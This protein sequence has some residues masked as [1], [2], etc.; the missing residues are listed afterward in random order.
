M[1]I[2][3][4][5]S[6]IFLI[7]APAHAVDRSLQAFAAACMFAT[8]E[9]RTNKPYYPPGWDTAG[10]KREVRPQ[11]LDALRSVTRRGVITVVEGDRPTDPAALEGL[12]MLYGTEM[13]FTGDH[14][15]GM[16]YRVMGG[17]VL[18][19]GYSPRLARV[20]RGEMNPH[21]GYT[22]LV[23]ILGDK[24]FEYLYAS[25]MLPGSMGKTF[26]ARE[27]LMQPEFAAAAEK[28]HSIRDELRSL[29]PGESPAEWVAEHQKRLEDAINTFLDT[30]E[31]LF[32][33]GVFIKQRVEWQTGDAKKQLSSKKRRT[34]EWTREYLSDLLD[35]HAELGFHKENPASERMQN[36]IGEL[37]GRRGTKFVN[38]LLFSPQDLLVQEK[39][40]LRMSGKFMDEWRVT[41]IDGQ[42]LT[43]VP[44]YGWEYSPQ[45]AAE[46]SAFFKEFSSK[47]SHEFKY[48]SGGADVAFTTDGKPK[49][50]ELNTGAEAGGVMPEFDPVNSNLNL[51]ALLGKPTPLVQKLG[52]LFQA[53]VEEQAAFVRGAK[54]YFEGLGLKEEA[55][56]N[57]SADYVLVYFRDRYLQEWDKGKHTKKEA[58]SILSKL[59]K[60]DKGSTPSG[61]EIIASA[62]AYL[63]LT[64]E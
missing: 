40:P 22:H 27:M 41:F 7:S 32:P 57:D 33:D 54:A 62:E 28:L 19:P 24:W 16:P 56:L 30:G 44:R 60:I 61:K 31:K 26:R 38:S 14:P 23:P 3:L 8:F 47:A 2:A 36:K 18:H 37:E 1:R 35:I 4:T 59:K 51:S 43:V 15:L 10:I 58:R 12:Q 13:Y 52:G 21:L 46:V 34:E 50:I 11:G 55:R 64:P 20:L 25:Q 9:S 6:I 63:G 5:L 53:P 17:L 42:V 49:L 48:L 29:R 39:L 45:K